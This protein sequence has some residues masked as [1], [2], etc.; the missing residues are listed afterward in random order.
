[1]IA[2]SYTTTC[3]ISTVARSTK[4]MVS[5]L[6]VQ[7]KAQGRFALAA[8]VLYAPLHPL[9]VQ[10]RVLRKAQP[11]GGFSDERKSGRP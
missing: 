10:V 9:G 5:Q 1:M 7:C 11:L 6:Q 4:Q 2:F 3:E 8:G